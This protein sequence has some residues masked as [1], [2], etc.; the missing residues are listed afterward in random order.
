MMTGGGPGALSTPC[1]SISPAREFYYFAHETSGIQPN[2]HQ[3]HMQ[4]QQSLMLNGH[5]IE[6]HLFYGQDSKNL[7]QTA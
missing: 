5:L 7:V 3:I 4:S 6:A 2:A 1:L